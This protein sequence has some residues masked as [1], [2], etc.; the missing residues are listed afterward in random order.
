MRVA[1]VVLLAVCSCAHPP[2]AASEHAY[3]H[4]FSNPDEWAPRFEDPARDVW[5]K[6]DQVIAALKLKPNDRIADIGSATGYF[7]VRLARALPSARIWGSDIEPQMTR[8]L[9]ERAAN[10][11]LPNLQAVVATQTDPRLPEKVELV[12]MVDTFHH[13]GNRATYFE[14]LRRCCVAIDGRL[15][16]LDFKP[17]SPVGPPIEHRVSTAVLEAELKAAGWEK[18]EQHDF[19]P[20]QYFLIFTPVR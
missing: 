9:A 3:P 10:E 8:Y 14:N 16:I 7:P 1:I 11:G 5:Q 13:I 15:A 12:L 20:Y 19:L 2:H 18:V 6:P 4:R 17:D